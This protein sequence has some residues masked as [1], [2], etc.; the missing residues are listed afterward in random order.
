MEKRNT[1]A[2]AFFIRRTKANQ[3]GL[4][5]VF[6]RITVNGVS[7]EMRIQ[8]NIAAENWNTERGLPIGR[9]KISREIHDFIETMRAKALYIHREMELDRKIITAKSIKEELQGKSTRQRT[10]KQC[11]EEHNAQIRK[12]SD[13]DISPITVR[14]YEKSLEVLLDFI[15]YQY[16][17]DDYH[18]SDIDPQ[19][20]DSY[21]VYL[22]ANLKLGQSS[23]VKR[24]KNLKKI[25]R[26]AMMNNWISIDPFRFTK[27]V[28][29]KTEKEF[30]VKEEIERIIAKNLTTRQKQTESM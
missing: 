18:I 5:P 22:K 4:S 11:F 1:F 14:R 7:T 20:I 24:L 6:L 8:R 10:I 30:L 23:A 15:K 19:F 25:T 12:L 17:E 9:D 2:L 28:E 13:V 21:T 3:K 26:I 27:L 16:N 29:K